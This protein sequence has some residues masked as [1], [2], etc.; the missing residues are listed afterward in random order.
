LN[1]AEKVAVGVIVG[2]SVAVAVDV[3]VD[4]LV[5]V[6]VRVGVDVSVAKKVLIGLLGPVNQTISRIT[7]PST[8]TPAMIKTRFGLPR[9]LRF[10]RELMLL[11]GEDEIGGLLF[12]KSV[13]F[14]NALIQRWFPVDAM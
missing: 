5:G 6:N 9:C 13:P 12:M 11:D 8:S 1:G 7:P 4:V 3:G 14:Y 2:V 10:R